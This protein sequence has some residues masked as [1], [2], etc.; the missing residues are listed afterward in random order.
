[1]KRLILLLTFC[2]LGFNASAQ[3]WRLWRKP[4]PAITAVQMQPPVI[5]IKKAPIPLNAIIEMELDVSDYVKGVQEASMIKVAKHHMR[6]R[7]YVDASY[8]FN[9]L[10]DLYV[11]QNRFSEAKWFL[12]QSNAIARNTDNNRHIISN[13]LILADIKV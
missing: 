4:L 2:I 8:S 13:L 3:F 9:D 10:A 7:Q 1:M 11:R 6:F 5:A 12:L